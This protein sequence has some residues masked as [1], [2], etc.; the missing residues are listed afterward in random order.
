MGGTHWTCFDIT[1]NKSIYF[2]SFGGHKGVGLKNK[3]KKF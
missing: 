3:I 2:D 1:D